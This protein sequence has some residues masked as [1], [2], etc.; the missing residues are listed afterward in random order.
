MKTFQA[1]GSNDLVLAGNGQLSIISDLEAFTQSAKEYMQAVLGEMIHNAD[2]GLPLEA[3]V[4]GGTPNVAQ[5]EAAGRVRLMQ[6]PNAQEVVSFTARL[7]GD[8]MSYTAIIRT[9][10]GEVPLSG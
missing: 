9:P 7:L 3:V 1:D 8:V 5:F 6:V 2:Q 10:W 4:W